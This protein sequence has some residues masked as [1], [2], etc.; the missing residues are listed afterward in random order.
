M[1]NFVPESAICEEDYLYED[2]ILD[3]DFIVATLANI[4]M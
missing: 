1:S 4:I 2:V 3:F